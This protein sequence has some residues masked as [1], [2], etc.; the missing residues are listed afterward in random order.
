MWYD[1]IEGLNR[2]PQGVEDMTMKV[3]TDFKSLKFRVLIVVEKDDPGYHAF[4]PSLPGL[5]MPGDTRKEALENAK[6]A[7]TLMLKAMI[8]DGD[9][10]PID[11]IIPQKENM[12]TDSSNQTCSGLEEIQV[13]L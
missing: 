13:N 3:K 1:I 6:E 12:V 7:A 10:I 11:V 2:R 5:H 4:A 9:S 8:E